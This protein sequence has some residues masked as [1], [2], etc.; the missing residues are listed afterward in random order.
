[1]LVAGLHYRLRLDLEIVAVAA[2]G[3]REY[4]PAGQVLDAQK[5]D[6]LALVFCTGGVE[7]GVAGKRDICMTSYLNLLPIWIILSESSGD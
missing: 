5:E 1:L 4:G 6:V 3:Q 7:D 2:S